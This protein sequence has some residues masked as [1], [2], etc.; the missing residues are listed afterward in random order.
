MRIIVFATHK[1]R[2]KTTLATCLAVAAQEAGESV[3]IF[4]LDPKSCAVR[5]V[6]QT[7]GPQSAGAH[8]GICPAK[9][10]VTL[11]VIDPVLESPA[12]LAAVKT[13]NLTIVPTKPSSFDIWAAEVTGR[14]MHFM[15]ERFA[16][17]LNQCPTQRH[18]RHMRDSV[19]SLKAIGPPLNI[20]SVLSENIRTASGFR[21]FRLRDVVPSRKAQTLY[22][23]TATGL[24]SQNAWLPKEDSIITSSPEFDHRASPSHQA[25]SIT[26][27]CHRPCQDLFRKARHHENRGIFNCHF[28]EKL[29][30]RR[31][32]FTEP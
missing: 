4:D 7:H 21:L 26:R 12:A 27:L 20:R 29:F 13:A 31:H 23:E 17:L 1:G 14:R 6:L 11:V 32:L 2:G 8:G 10:K 9:R 22:A 15:N 24:N 5:W 25:K 19:A 28:W 30:R 16:I 18:S 3:V